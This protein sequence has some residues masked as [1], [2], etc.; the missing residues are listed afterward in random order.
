MPTVARP[1]ITRPGGAAVRPAEIVDAGPAAVDRFLEF[2]AA[3]IANARTQAAY[4]RAVG[5]FLAWCEARRLGL[6]AVSPLHVAAY[7]SGNLTGSASLTV[8][9]S[10]SQLTITGSMTF[11]GETAE[12]PAITG[13]INSTG[14]FTPTGGGFSSEAADPTCGTIT[15]SSSTITFSGSSLRLV[16]SASSEFCGTLSLSGTLTR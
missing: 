7:I 14:F 3:R 4:G 5:Q 16:E 1:E 8:V 15:T 13:T 6:A 9:Q 11:F 12:L 2:F 10:G